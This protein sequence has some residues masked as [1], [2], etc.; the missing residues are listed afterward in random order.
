MYQFI[1]GPLLWFSFIFFIVGCVVH[2]VRYVMGL[3]WKLDRVTYSKNVSYGVSGAIR[4]IFFWLLPFGTRSW[5]NNPGYTLIIFMFHFCI[6]I[7]PFFLKA[8]NIILQER[9]GFSLWTMP[10]SVTDILT[11]C[12]IAT[13]MILLLR[14]F[15]LAQV[16]II[17]NFHDILVLMITIAPFVTGFMAYHQISDSKFWL[18][19]HVL[20]GELMLIAIPLTKLSHVVRFFCSRAQLGFDFGIKRGGMKSGGLNW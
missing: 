10:E 9:W 1:T 18:I 8:H 4:S 11:L 7:T 13:A 12:L 20:T 2:G 6:L 5:R 16:R 3:D 19:V 14:R 15:A 17:T